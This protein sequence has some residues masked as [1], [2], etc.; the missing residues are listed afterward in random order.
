MEIA[1]VSL[2]VDG[3]KFESE[4]RE[5]L[6]AEASLLDAYI[7]LQHSD[8]KLPRGTYPNPRTRMDSLRDQINA[9]GHLFRDLVVRV[10]VITSRDLE[11]PVT[12]NPHLERHE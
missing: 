8:F 11:F 5:S 7:R 4:N 12:W 6:K 2:L 9:V 1:G 3:G 10:I